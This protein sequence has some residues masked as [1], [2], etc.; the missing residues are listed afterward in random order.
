MFQWEAPD[1]FKL[2]DDRFTNYVRCSLE[3]LMDDSG[4]SRKDY[5]KLIRSSLATSVVESWRSAASKGNVTALTYLGYFHQRWGALVGLD[6]NKAA[7][8]YKQAARKKHAPAQYKL[9]FCYQYGWN[10]VK[11]KDQEKAFQLREEAALSGYAPAQM[12]LFDHYYKKDIKKAIEWLRKSADQ[13]FAHA[14]DRLGRLFASGR[15]VKKDL[16]KALWWY[17]KSARL[18]S[19][20]AKLQ[21]ENYKNRKGYFA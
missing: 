8:F 4:V 13:N 2:G 14:Q 11:E 21:L 1:D 16:K 5:K 10:G 19:V 17:R 12:A 7:G 20:Q 3:Q 6:K 18:G 15:L 9:A